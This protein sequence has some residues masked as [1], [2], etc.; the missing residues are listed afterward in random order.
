M[1]VK[2]NGRCNV[3]LPMATNSWLH[4]DCLGE[5]GAALFTL[6]WNYLTDVG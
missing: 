6:G 4:H 3:E 5:V 2:D 1:L